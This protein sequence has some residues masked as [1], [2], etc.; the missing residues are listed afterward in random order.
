MAKLQL[1]H[2]P[3]IRWSYIPERVLEYSR[4]CTESRLVVQTWLVYNRTKIHDTDRRTP[5][6]YSQFR[7]YTGACT[8]YD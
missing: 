6:L 4:S 7:A 5:E 1:A 3:R 8:H 2:D